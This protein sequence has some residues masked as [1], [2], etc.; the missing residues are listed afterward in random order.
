MPRLQ[1][2]TSLT[3]DLSLARELRCREALGVGFGV[4]FGL[5]LGFCRPHIARVGTLAIVVGIIALA[6]QA[7][8]ADEGGASFWLEGSY[9]SF[10]AV[11]STPGWQITAELYYAGTR[12]SGAAAEERAIRTEGGGTQLVNANVSKN[13]NSF[14]QT[15]TITPAYA[16]ATPVFGAQLVVEVAA[17]VGQ[18]G[19]GLMETLV[20][21][22][23]PNPVTVQENRYNAVTSFGDLAP[24]VSLLWSRGVDNFIVY[25]T[26]NIPVGYFNPQ[27]TAN[28]GIGHG[29]IDAGGGYTYYNQKTGLEFSFV[30]GVTYN[31]IDPLTNYTNG[32]D[33]HL[34][35]GASVSPSPSAYVGV[36][37][38]AYNQF[39]PDIGSPPALGPIRSRVIGIGPQFGFNVPVG[40]GMQADVSLRAYGEFAAQDR[41]AG[42]DAWLTLS[43]SPAA[44]TPTPATPHQRH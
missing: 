25:A 41:P 6:S 1:R 11:P 24:Q 21:Q 17:L 10:A 16:F 5:G 33:W 42:W 31:L 23:G 7:A 27:S 32:V 8:L 43:L 34:D 37:G 15:M 26:G 44:P 13:L 40:S 39:T 2:D 4:A 38:Y 19:V 35:W 18:N 30:T 36:A 3:G 28:I 12:D 20:T 22:G 14:L 9:A 29:A